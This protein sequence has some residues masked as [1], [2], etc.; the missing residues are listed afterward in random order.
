MATD[1]VIA[2]NIGQMRQHMPVCDRWVYLDHAAVA[3]LPSPV[4]KA[5][6]EW[7]TDLEHNGAVHWG[8]W[9][10]LVEGIRNRAARRLRAQPEE[11][12]VVRN[13]TE[14]VSII[15]EGWPWKAGD[16]LV[17]PGSEFPSNLYPWLNLRQ[18]GVEVRVVDV[19]STATNDRFCSALEQAC[20]DHTAIIACSWVDYASGRRRNLSRLG[21]IAARRGARL[22]VDAIQGLGVLPLDVSSLPIDFLAADGHKWMLGPEGAGILYIREECLNQLRMT[23]PGWNSVVQSGDYSNKSLNLKSTAGRYEAGTYPMPGIAGLH[24][25]LQLTSQISDEILESRLLEVRRLFV[26]A[27][28]NAGLGTEDLPRE[29]QSGIISFTVSGCDPR[30]LMKR[31]RGQSIIASVRDGR[32]RVSPHVYNS[33]DESVRFATAVRELTA[34]AQ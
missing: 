11:I 25:S 1:P 13:T 28:E 18:R 34:A 20:D 2:E 4:A 31:L 8:V 23:G 15:A 29:E 32:L 16:N 24:A 26:A 7:A 14:G 3:P 30:Q 5:V 12:C 33:E 17:V 27:G 19:E 9:R 10:T 6:R 21:G 22:F